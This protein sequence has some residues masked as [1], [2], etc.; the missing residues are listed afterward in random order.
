MKQKANQESNYETRCCCNCSN[1]KSSYEDKNVSR[2]P[3]IL[4]SK[5]YIIQKYKYKRS[6]IVSD[7]ML[8]A[9]A[10]EFVITSKFIDRFEELKDAINH[11]IEET[12]SLRADALVYWAKNYNTELCIY[13]INDC[14][15]TR[16]EAELALERELNE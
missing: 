3:F 2:K 8:L 1:Y 4:G 11:H 15:L 16:E 14:Y 9:I 12:D 5:I 6:T 10:R 7:Q 13:P